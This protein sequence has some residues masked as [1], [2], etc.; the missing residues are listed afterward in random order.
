MQRI[1]TPELLDTDACPP[2]EVAVSLRDM[3]RINRWFGGVSTTVELVRR[4]SRSTGITELS[5]L[6]V[7]AGL[8]EVPAIVARKLS[9]EGITV[10]VTLLDRA[11]THLPA[12]SRAVAADALALPF[13]DG[14]FDLVSCNLFAHHL[15]PAQLAGFV[16]EALR[17]S[18]SAVLINDLVRHRMHV[19]L[20]YAGFPLM[21]SHVS[22]VDG[23]ASVR[24]AYIPEE[25][26]HILMSIPT[27]PKPRIEIF[28]HPLFR[29]GI[30]IW[31][32]ACE[33][34]LTPSAPRPPR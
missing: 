31:K 26:Q 2:E 24:R 30:T 22:R 34:H 11:R 27:E 1:N 23:V 21:R 17:V 6:D 20:V 10:S 3:A 13:S 32:P 7:A 29:M 5:L 4:A 15:E 9:R 19:A 12:S 33:N 16:R 28:R 8:G 18:R 14:T 25:I